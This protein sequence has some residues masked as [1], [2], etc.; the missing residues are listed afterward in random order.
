MYCCSLLL[1]LSCVIV[2]VLAC[3]HRFRFYC[4]F[5]DVQG[6]ASAR[7]PID[8][9]IQMTACR[10]LTTNHGMPLLCRSEF[11]LAAKPCALQCVTAGCLSFHPMAQCVVHALKAWLAA[12]VSLRLARLPRTASS[13]LRSR[14]LRSTCAAAPVLLAHA[15]VTKNIL[16]VQWVQNLGTPRYNSAHWVQAATYF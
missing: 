14:R 5:I 6:I 4:L 7:L 3:A 2:D 16:F 10:V 15:E 8:E 12:R 1:C 11:P 13:A 9:Y